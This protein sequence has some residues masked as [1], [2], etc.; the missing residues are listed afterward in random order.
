MEYS[1]LNKVKRT[2]R[3]QY[4]KLQFLFVFFDLQNMMLCLIMFHFTGNLCDCL[5]N[6][7]F[8][9]CNFI[10]LDNDVLLLLLV[11]A[12]SL[13][14]EKTSTSKTNF[15]VTPNNRISVKYYFCCSIRSECTHWLLICLKTVALSSHNVT[16]T[17]E[18]KDVWKKIW[19]T[20][21]R[22]EIFMPN[23]KCDIHLC[24]L[25]FYMYIQLCMYVCV[26][27]CVRER[28]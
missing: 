27:V 24:T 21:L 17:S 12:F 20:C 14:I 18:L 3:I 11:E 23:L 8:F 13:H 2:A 6:V 25:A 10:S 1:S 19:D 16:L 26:C 4:L 7:L 5:V 22:Y 15:T 9:F 28:I